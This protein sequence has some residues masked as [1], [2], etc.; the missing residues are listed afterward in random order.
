MDFSSLNV[1]GNISEFLL[2]EGDYHRHPVGRII[3]SLITVLIAFIAIIG[4]ATVVTVS[5]K[6]EFLR[7]QAENILIAYLSSVDILTALFMMILSAIAVALD[8]WP[9]GDEICKLH[10][11][12]NYLFACSSSWNLAVISVDRAIAII[13]PFQYGSKMTTKVMLTL[14]GIIFIISFIVASTCALP[15]WTSF[16]YSEAVCAM[17]YTIGGSG[18]FYVYNLGCFTCYYIPIIILYTSNYIIIMTARKSDKAQP[19]LFIKRESSTSTVKEYTESQNHMR[20]TI[21]SL[22]VIVITYY[23]CFTPYALIKQAKVFLEYDV[24]P[25]LNY[26]STIFIYVASATNPFIYAIL[27]KDFRKAFK[28]LF[29]SFS[30]RTFP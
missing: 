28:R 6:D 9:L 30:R 19:T 18:M 25:Q 21:R 14:C 8:Y 26:S 11:V 22:I 16:N 15:D 7:S 24:P 10:A 1:S 20:K 5:F 3:G 23:V 2:L 27:R 4:N 17:E 12:F 29:R 13:Y